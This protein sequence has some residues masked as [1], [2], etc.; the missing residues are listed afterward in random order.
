MAKLEIKSYIDGKILF[1][2][3]CGSIKVC[4][5]AAVKSRAYLSGAY[6]SGAYL[7]RAYLK[8]IKNASLALA[9]T[10]IV[11]QEGAFVGWK[12]LGNGEIAELVIPH[13]AARVNAAGSRKC[14]AARVFVHAMW[15]AAGKVITGPVRGRHDSKTKY[16]VGKE[17]HPDKFDPS[18]TEECSNGIHFF[19][20]KEEAEAY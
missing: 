3:E 10:R 12:K 20:T 17:T 6:L 11:P 8:D 2:L 7:S 4:L 1:S 13:D 14:R 5:E 19:I 15:D 18:I 9:Q 16:E